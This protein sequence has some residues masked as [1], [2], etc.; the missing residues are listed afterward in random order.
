MHWE[1]G[2]NPKLYVCQ[3]A[4]NFTDVLD[5]Q[6]RQGEWQERAGC[7]QSMQQADP[8]AIL[9]PLHAPSTPSQG[10]S[11]AQQVISLRNTNF[12]L[13]ICILQWKASSAQ[14]K[15]WEW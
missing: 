12:A 8:L 1:R 9:C 14:N 4:A 7:H 3:V 2:D 5:N 15:L 13:Q 11:I 10:N 6:S